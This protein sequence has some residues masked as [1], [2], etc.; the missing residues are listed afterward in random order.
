MIVIEGLAV[1]SSLS[2]RT[3]LCTQVFNKLIIGAKYTEHCSFPFKGRAR[4][5]MG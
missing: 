4:V 3:N 2:R 5:G 1:F